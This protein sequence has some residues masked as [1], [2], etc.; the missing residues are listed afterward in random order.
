MAVIPS[1]DTVVSIARQW[2]G[3]PYKWGGNDPVV[4][5][6][7]DCSGYV[8]WVLRKVGIEYADT[9]AQGLWNMCYTKG[10]CFVKGQ[11]GQIQEP[12]TNAR[13]IAGSLLFARDRE[14]LK[15]KHVAFSDGANNTIEAR[16]S[17]T[18]DRGTGVFEMRTYFNNSALIPGVFYREK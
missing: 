6:G 11:E 1:G 3:Y 16:G 17:K 4:D 14:T 2:L 7:V 15:I 13:R 8:L 12:W 9:T 18:Q 5:G 10:L